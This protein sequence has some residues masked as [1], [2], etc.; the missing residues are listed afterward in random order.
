MRGRYKTRLSN[1]SQFPLT[2]P[3]EELERLNA[4]GRLAPGDLIPVLC[5]FLKAFADDDYET[6]I[7]I[8]AAR[9]GAV[10]RFGG[11]KAQREVFE[12]TLVVAYLRAGRV[13]P[14]G[15]C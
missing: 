6:V 15:S 13:K 5:Q 14:A 2:M 7:K 9:L 8:L 1:S 11:S 12:D 4:D 3:T 10:V